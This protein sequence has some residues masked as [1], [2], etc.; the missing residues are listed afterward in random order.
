M[1]AMFV[2]RGYLPSYNLGIAAADGPLGI[3]RYRTRIL[4][5][6]NHLETAIA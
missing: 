3:R 6:A 5:G 4:M 2:M 1:S